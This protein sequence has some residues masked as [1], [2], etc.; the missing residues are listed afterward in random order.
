MLQVS[1]PSLQQLAK[2]ERAEAIRALSCLR[3][4]VVGHPLRCSM[5]HDNFL[6]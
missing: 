6:V 4:E 5:L 1:L 3:L 2:L